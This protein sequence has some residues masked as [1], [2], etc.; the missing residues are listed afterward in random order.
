MVVVPSNH[1]RLRM[2]LPHVGVHVCELSNRGL[3][4]KRFRFARI[5][6]GFRQLE[7]EAL[8]IQTRDSLYPVFDRRIGS[9]Q[10]LS[11]GGKYPAVCV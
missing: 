2:K 5:H 6:D 4:T 7:V 10:S 9:K 3:H 8:D 11:V 1:A